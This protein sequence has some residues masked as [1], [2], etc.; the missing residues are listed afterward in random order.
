MDCKTLVRAALAACALAAPTFAAPANW[1]KAIDQL[2]AA[3]AAHPPKHGGVVFVGSSSIVMWKTLA[4][5]FPETNTINRGFGGSELADSVY[6]F[7]RIVA[8]YEPRLVVLYAGDN[9]LWG[10]KTPET[11][12]GDFRAFCAKLHA[13]LPHA[14]LAY[15]SIKPSPSRWSIHEKM[16]QANKLIAAECAKDPRRVFVDVFTPMLDAKGQPRPELFGP[17]MLHMNAD[18]Y[19]LWRSIVGPVLEP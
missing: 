16:E 14:R 10:G 8:P 19:A 18:G 4:A 7:D 1:A 3:D 13:A 6:Y 15:I 2:T 11:V 9:D 17:D 5:D 12:A